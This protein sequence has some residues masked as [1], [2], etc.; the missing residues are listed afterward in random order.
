MPAIQ[1]K[2]RR[3]FHRFP[4]LPAEIRHLIWYFCLPRHIVDFDF[5]DGMVRNENQDR[6]GDIMDNMYKC[7]KILDVKS[8]RIPPII[9][10]VCREAYEVA[11]RHGSTETSGKLP[12]WLQPR[13][14]RM[15]FYHGKIN[16]QIWYSA[17]EVHYEH[18]RSRS[19]RL[20]AAFDW[21]DRVNMPLA[22][23]HLDLYPFGFESSLELNQWQSNFLAP[24]IAFLNE[25][26]TGGRCQAFPCAVETIVLHATRDQAADSGLFGRLGEDL[27]QMVDVE[28]SEGIQQYYEFW[29]LSSPC[30]R[31]T[32]Y[33]MSPEWNF[34]LAN[35]N[36]RSVVDDW[37]AKFQYV[38]LAA[39]WK[40]ASTTAHPNDAKLEDVFSPRCSYTY[41]PDFD[42]HHIVESHPWVIAAKE[43]L[44][45][46]LPRIC[47]RL[48]SD[49]RCIAF[50]NPAR[51]F[52]KPWPSLP[53]ARIL[54]PRAR[55]TRR[56][57]QRKRWNLSSLPY[58]QSRKTPQSIIQ[59]AQA[60]KH[61]AYSD[62]SEPPSPCYLFSRDFKAR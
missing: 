2:I 36:L 17:L 51:T 31:L 27:C 6:P 23:Y 60:M 13:V 42:R 61:A 9:M 18:N 7:R 40:S 30:R 57:R 62:C 11:L 10:R 55:R 46:V 52:R 43:W 35:D 59:R 26:A 12:T 54:V 45:T 22:F 49:L 20:A 4:L 28:D 14:D 37:L 5:L 16:W 50:V 24:Q 25:F 44:P 33:T 15:L 56:I 53:R 1:Y 3:R 48:C 47:F 58:K 39:V 38:L 32:E 41:F 34:F 21:A 19:R 29:R 8:N